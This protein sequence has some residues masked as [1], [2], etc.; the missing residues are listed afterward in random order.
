M[1]W[2]WHVSLL[3]AVC[4]TVLI[5][6]IVMLCRKWPAFYMR[7]YGMPPTEKNL[8]QCRRVLWAVPFCVTIN[9]VEWSEVFIWLSSP[10][11][12]DILTAGGST[13][14]CSL[15]N[16]LWT[17]LAGAAVTLQPLVCAVFFY[18]T[19]ERCDFY[20]TAEQRA[21]APPR[22]QY[23]PLEPATRHNGREFV[24]DII[25]SF[26]GTPVGGEEVLGVESIEDFDDPSQSGNAVNRRRVG[27]SNDLVGEEAAD[28]SGS[29]ERMLVEEEE[30]DSTGTS[31]ATVQPIDHSCEVDYEGYPERDRFLLVYLSAFFTSALLWL[32]SAYSTFFPDSN[33]SYNP[34]YFAS[35]MN[36]CTCS[37]VGQYGHLVWT[38][39]FPCSL[40]HFV[41][42]FFPYAL[43]ANLAA[44]FYAPVWVAS[45]MFFS[46][47]LFLWELVWFWGS[48]E[49]YSVWCW[50]GSAATIMYFCFA[51]ALYMPG[52]HD[53][54]MEE[55][56][57]NGTIIQFFSFYKAG[58]MKALNDSPHWRKFWAQ[59]G[60]RCG[61]P[62]A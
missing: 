18:K 55:S 7:K 4:E 58:T 41:P 44:V 60:F 48:T 52:F 49:A 35:M 14:Q 42:N 37:Y 16:M 62:N 53:Y 3:F 43:F 36:S 61:N 50:T 19:H 29:V 23:Q 13:C 5:V 11:S 6:G 39:V 8:Q 54:M 34:H 31:N 59:L 24:T 38:F 1:C 15:M 21:A 47:P 40:I 25:S 46:L 32:G 56:G 27:G 12:A 33:C 2:S 20:K 57:F 30:N 10:V 17:G 45:P 9:V 22:E 51:C 28:L 26:R